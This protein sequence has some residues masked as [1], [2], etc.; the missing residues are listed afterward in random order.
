[1]TLIKTLDRIIEFWQN[2]SDTDWLVR[3]NFKLYIAHTV[4]NSEGQPLANLIWKSFERIPRR[5]IAWE[6]IYG[7]N[8]CRGLPHKSGPW[9]NSDL[10]LSGTWQRCDVG[11]TFALSA[12]GFWTASTKEPGSKHLQIS[13]NEYKASVKEAVYVV[14]GLYDRKTSGFD[15]V[16]QRHAK[17][18]MPFY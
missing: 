11:E 15:P 14:I 9:S 10:D 16:C 6:P 17:F 4:L 1:M 8:W 2:D 13:R 3:A 5:M 7:L 18:S 12:S